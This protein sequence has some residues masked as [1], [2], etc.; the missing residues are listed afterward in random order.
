MDFARSYE[1]LLPIPHGGWVSC[2]TSLTEEQR[3][4]YRAC[5]YEVN[6]II[7][8]VPAWVMDVGLITP[9]CF[10]QNVFNFRLGHYFRS[11]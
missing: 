9:W 4:F 6:E 2:K 7:N 1:V 8:T 10:L 5:G 3:D 11:M